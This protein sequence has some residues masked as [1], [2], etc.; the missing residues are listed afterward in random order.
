MGDTS[1]LAD[2]AVINFLKENVETRKLLET[3]AAFIDK[4][5]SGN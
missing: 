2:V 1:T 4:V 3:K 5:A